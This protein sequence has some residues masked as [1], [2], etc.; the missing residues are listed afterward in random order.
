ML[1]SAKYKK[2]EDSIWELGV[3]ECTSC[4][5]TWS[6]QGRPHTGGNV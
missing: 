1:D 6:G 2:N 4:N 3:S 5:F